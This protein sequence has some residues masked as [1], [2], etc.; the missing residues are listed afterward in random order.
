MLQD[1]MISHILPEELLQKYF[2]GAAT[3]EETYIVEKLKDHP[4]NIAAYNR[5]LANA[6]ANTSSSNAN[7]FSVQF[8]SV[9]NKPVPGEIWMLKNIIND[10][11]GSKLLP[12]AI[13]RFVYI[14][15]TPEALTSENNDDNH[16][17]LFP[18]YNTFLCLPVSLEPQLATHKDLTVEANN[19][20]LG[21]GFMIATELEMNS[22]VFCLRKKVATL[23][24]DLIKKLLNLYFFAGGMEYDTVLLDDT[25]RGEF[26]DNDFGDKFEYR[27][28]LFENFSDQQNYVSS[29]DNYF[30]VDSIEN[31]IKV[32]IAEPREFVYS[33][34][35][36][37]LQKYNVVEKILL[38][39]DLMFS[40]LIEISEKGQLYCKLFQKHKPLKKVL[41]II[42]RC[43]V[44]GSNQIIEYKLE[45]KIEV[46]HIKIDLRGKVVSFE[47]L[48]DESRYFLKSQEF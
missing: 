3:R 30:A 15:T 33:E 4:D 27:D 5:L 47:I 19:P 13:D 25:P 40:C 18:E 21:I 48:V 43:I 31:S 20:Y 41:K 8:S 38:F 11:E 12:S 17:D 37:D 1:Y 22:A 9:T 16:I 28:V 46:Q 10:A 7:I 42:I 26:F 23:S 36:D 39:D 2:T 32:L 14:L 45:K 24:S 34:T 29:I 35:D 6:S 44:D